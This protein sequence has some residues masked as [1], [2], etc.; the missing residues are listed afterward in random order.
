[1]A[2][3]N[4]LNSMEQNENKVITLISKRFDINLQQNQNLNNFKSISTN[5]NSNTKWHIESSLY[6]DVSRLLLSLIY[7][8]NLDK[9]LDIICLKN[10]KLLKPKIP[11]CYGIISK[12]G[13]FIILF[14]F[15][16]F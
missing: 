5:N 4:S 10:L 3:S 14:F 8:W 6:L 16:T 9:N 15:I 2:S 12:K 11:I 1:M 13:K 7:G